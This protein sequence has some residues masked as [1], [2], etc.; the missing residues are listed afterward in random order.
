MENN[1]AL[2][3]MQSLTGAMKARKI[4]LSAGISARIVKPDSKLTEQGCG[5]ALELSVSEAKRA[6]QL[7]AAKRYPPVRIIL[8]DAP[9]TP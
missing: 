9:T 2:F 1:K 5:Y 4:L 6:A 8:P 3:T 7:L